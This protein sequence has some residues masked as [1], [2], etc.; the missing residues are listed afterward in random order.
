MPYKPA[1]WVLSLSTL[2]M[3]IAIH[4]AEFVNKGAEAM[5]LLLPTLVK[6]VDNALFVIRLP[7]DYFEELA[8]SGFR[9][10]GGACKQ[11][12]A[13]SHF[14]KLISR[15]MYPTAGRRRCGGLSVRRPLGAESNEKYRQGVRSSSSAGASGC[16]YA[17][18]LGAVYRSGVERGR[19]CL[20]GG[21]RSVL[22][23]R[24]NIDARS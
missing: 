2:L 8:D 16:F 7:T 9:P 1:I 19:P 3:N 23:T 15:L 12:A 13:P 17:S 20:I 18:G 10:C 21:F 6:R 4:G 24:L 11:S 22:Y 14:S 5:F